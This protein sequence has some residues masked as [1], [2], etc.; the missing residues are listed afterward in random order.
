MYNVIKNMNMKGISTMYRILI[1]DD[2]VTINDMLCKFLRKNGYE[3]FSV[4]S[5]TEAILFLEKQE[6]DL[7]ILDLMLPGLTG[8][9]VLEKIMSQKKIPTIGLSA[10]DDTQSK[11]HLLKNGADDYITKPFDINEL[12]VRVEVILRRIYQNNIKNV[13]TLHFR[14]LHLNTITMQVTLNEKEVNLTKNEYAILKML[15]EHPTQVFTKDMI[16][17]TLYCEIF[18][19]TENA[20]NV[21]ISNIRKKL[22][23]IDSTKPYI[24]TVWGIGFKMENE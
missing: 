2:D 24:K 21:H 6:V 20:I 16:Y 13:R 14:N 9:Q 15:M 19:G 12:L 18:T 22:A 1:I 17:E 10:K 3:P 11:I 23:A 7:L 8:E 4:Y 5:G